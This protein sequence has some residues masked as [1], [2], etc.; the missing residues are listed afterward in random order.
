[1]RHVVPANCLSTSIMAVLQCLALLIFAL[2]NV[3]FSQETCRQYAGGSVFPEDTGKTSGHSLSWIK[4]VISKPAPYWEGT[5]VVKGEIKQLRLTDY[6][7]KYVVFFFYPLDLYVSLCSSTFVCPTEIIAFNDR[8]EEFIALDTEVIACSVDSHFTHLAWTK[9]PRQ[10][11]GLGSLNIPLLSD[12][13]HQISKEY[14]VYLD[15]LGHTLRGLFIIDRKGI[16]R[17]ITMNDLP[18]G[19]SVDETLRLVQAFQYTDTHGEVCPVN[20]QPGGDT[21]IPNPEEKL[22]YFAKKTRKE[23]L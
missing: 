20:W 2:P 5:A 22:K 8:L 18:V 16:L 11:G 13:T 14:G 6:L 17:Q 21:I 15:D 7:G 12:M 19:R 23:D 3:I 10:E 9:T 4:A 1:M